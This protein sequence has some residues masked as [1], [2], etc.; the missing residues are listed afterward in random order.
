MSAMTESAATSSLRIGHLAV[1][2][3]TPRPDR[4]V[5]IVVI[6]AAH[7]EQFGQGWLN[8]AGLVDGAALDDCRF[9]VPVPRQSETG[10]R[11]RQHRLLQLRFLPALAVVDGYIDTPDPA[12]AAPG[13]AADLVE[14]GRRQPLAAGRAR[15]DGLGFHIECEL[16]RLAIR[17]QASGRCIW[18]FLRV[19]KP[20][21]PSHGAGAATS[22]SYYPRSPAPAGEADNPA[23]DAAV[24][25]SDCRLASRRRGT[26]RSVC[27]ASSQPHRRL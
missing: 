21:P 1:G 3:D 23:A 6:V 24:L 17:H 27:C 4:V 26:S 7:R 14:A 5:V 12:V 25:R 18:T 10:Q 16:A 11:P 9:A 8:V 15:D 2:R 22:R 19:N 20:A 13:D